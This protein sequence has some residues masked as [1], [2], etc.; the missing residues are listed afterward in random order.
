M[1][2]I[3]AVNA[4]ILADT[5]GIC[6]TN[7]A[8]PLG[9]GSIGTAA[10]DDCVAN[11][12][13]SFISATAAICVIAN[14]LMGIMGNLPLAIAPGMGLNAY[15][16]Y[17][18]VGFFGTGMVTYQMALAAVFI[19]G[20]IFVFIS[21]IGL[22]T[23]L[24]TIVPK[25]IWLASSAGI[26]A[27]LAFIGLQQAEGLGVVTYNGATA[28]GLG[29]CPPGYRNHQYTFSTAQ[30]ESACILSDGAAIANPA[31][32]GWTPSSNY[33]CESAGVMR[34][35]QTWLG[36]A[37]GR[38]GNGRC[39]DGLGTMGFALAVA[40]GVAAA[41]ACGVMRSQDPLGPPAPLRI[42]PYHTSPL[43]HPPPTHS[44]PTHRQVAC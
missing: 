17:T 12:K 33:F 18:V 4:G 25:S 34:S 19:E 15:F 29:G 1:A 6:P 22:R 38:G 3:L 26:G 13:R 39:E 27:F 36:I 8:C 7:G 16:T 2:Y 44:H 41:P 32:S 5:G 23:W 42:H 20:F 24:T 43:H 10:C 30:L 31:N 40:A 9:P 11:T 37:G 28:V 14:F 21:V 35:G